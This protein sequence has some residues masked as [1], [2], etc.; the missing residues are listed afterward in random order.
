MK[1]ELF[2][3]FTGHLAVMAAI[4]II[5]RLVQGPREITRPAV[6]TVE[7]IRGGPL[8]TV[9]PEP[10][11]HLMQQTPKPVSIKKQAEKPKPKSDQKKADETIRRAGLGARVEG[12]TAIGYNFYIQQMLER[13]A[14]NWQDPQSRRSKDVTATVMFVIERDGGLSE[15]KLERGSGD[16]LF[17]ESC[18]RAVTVTGRLPPLPQEFTAPRLK[19]H[20]EF[21]H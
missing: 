21:E 17:D 14:E 15:I 8:E 11:T 10:T 3:S 12:A 20:L 6:I 19:I 5:A 7:I 1:R 13:I 2:I 9:K 16:V 4:G 18:V